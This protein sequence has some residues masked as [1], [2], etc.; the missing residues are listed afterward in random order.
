MFSIMNGG[1][2]DSSIRL[3]KDGLPTYNKTHHISRN[4]NNNNNKKSFQG[5]YFILSQCKRIGNS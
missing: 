1:F 2:V 4:I 5:F 3:L